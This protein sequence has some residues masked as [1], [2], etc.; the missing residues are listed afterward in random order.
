MRPVTLKAD[1][2]L[3]RALLE[4]T[5]EL[6]LEISSAVLKNI[7]DDACKVAIMEKLQAKLT[8]LANFAAGWNGR[9]GLIN[10]FHNSA[11]HDLLRNLIN[12]QIEQ[13]TEEL[14][15]QSVTP[16]IEKVV[17]DKLGDLQKQ[18]DHIID[19]SFTPEH[20]QERLNARVAELFGKGNG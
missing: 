18:I 13:A 7:S 14:I 8:E 2:A 10:P 16:V 11:L 20:I 5:P 4:S 9:S 15:V 1:T 12:A 19:Q 6:K 3:I 17:A